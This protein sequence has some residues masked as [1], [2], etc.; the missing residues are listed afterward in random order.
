[1]LE[2]DYF[3]SRW[4]ALIILGIA[5]EQIHALLPFA[6]QLEIGDVDCLLKHALALT[7]LAG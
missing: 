5:F 6:L 1:M 2:A 7:A 4:L 3:A